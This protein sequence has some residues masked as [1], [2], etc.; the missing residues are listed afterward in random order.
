M[1]EVKA[2]TVEFPYRGSGQDYTR[3]VRKL[4]YIQCQQHALAEGGHKAIVWGSGESE[5]VDF[6]FGSGASYGSC[7]LPCGG[8]EDRDLKYR[9]R[10][11]FS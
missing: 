5:E 9:Q 7:G 2:I 1:L 8:G 6:R 11:H 3:R 4:D 10:C